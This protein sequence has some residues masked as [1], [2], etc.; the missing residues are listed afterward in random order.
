MIEYS[1]SFGHISPTIAGI[2]LTLLAA[3]PVV[4]ASRATWQVSQPGV[5]HFEKIPSP[6][7]QPAFKAFVPGYS[8]QARV[9]GFSFT[10]P[11]DAGRWS[12]VNGS[13]RAVPEGAMPTGAVTNYFLGQQRQ[14]WRTKVQSFEKIRYRS[15]WPGI[16]VVLYG[17]GSR[18]EYDFIVGPGAD[19]GQI[20]IRV[21]GVSRI[22]TDVDGSVIFQTDR[23]SFRQAPAILYQEI[24][25]KR[26]P[27]RGRYSLSPEGYVKLEVAD[28]DHRK[29]LIIDPVITLSVQ[30]GANGTESTAGIARD[31]L[32][33]LYLAGTTASSSLPAPTG[34]QTS[35]AG[36]SD[37]FVIKLDPQGNVLYSTY[38]GGSGDDHATGVA[39]DDQGNVYV[40][41]WTTSLNFPI[42]NALQPN[43]IG[44]R[45][46][47]LAKFSPDGQLLY[48]TYIGGSG[49]DEV[50]ALAVDSQ[51][52][53]F[54]AGVT[55]SKDFP[56]VGGIQGDLH[57]ATDGFVMKVNAGGDRIIFSTYL[58]GSDLDRCEAIAVDSIGRAYVA[59]STRS[60]DFPV[61]KPARPY[62][63]ETDAFIAR[64][65]SDGT[66]LEYA[67]FL[68]GSGNDEALGIAVDAANKAY[69]TGWTTSADFPV[70]SAFSA[71]LRGRQNAFVASLT[72]GGN[73]LTYSTYLGGTV[74][75]RG[76]AVR[77]NSDGEAFVTGWTRSPDFPTRSSVQSSLSGPQDA[78]FVRLSA[79]GA[80]IIDGSY[81]G[82][83]G[84]DDASAIL[85]DDEDRAYLAGDTVSR[86]AGR[87]D[88]PSS[89]RRQADNSGSG[90]FFAQ[91]DPCRYEFSWTTKSFDHLGGSD[92][93]L[94]T[95]NAP[96]CEWGV[97]EL[98]AWIS[99]QA[100]AAVGTG[101]LMLKVG[102][103]SGRSMRQGLIT[104]E[105]HKLTVS[106]NAL[107]TAGSLT[108]A[109]DYAAYATGQAVDFSGQFL[110]STGVA[111]ANATIGIQITQGSTNRSVS[112]AT[113]SAGN[114]TIVY[115]PPAGDVGVFQ[116]TASGTSN[117][118]TVTATTSF[119]IFG[120]PIQVP[121][122]S[123]PLGNTTWG[124]TGAVYVV[125]SGGVTVPQGATLT[126]QPGVIVKFQYEPGG[127]CY[128][129][130]YLDVKGSLVANGTAA[131]PIYFT[132][133]R[134]DAIGGDTNG[135]GNATSPA[136]GDWSGIRFDSG[137]TGSI[138]NAVIR[139]GGGSTYYGPN[140]A[141]LDIA[142][143]A[144][145]P[146]LGAGIQIT[147]SVTGLAISGSGTNVSLSGA[148]FARNTTGIALNTGS[149][150]ITGNT[151]TNNALGF[152]VAGATQG[153]ITNSTITTAAGGT[154]GQISAAYI[155]TLSGNTSSGAGLNIIKVQSG[156]H[157]TGLLTWG[158][159]IPYWVDQGGAH[160]D[161]G[162]TL[163]IQPGVIVKFRYAPGG[164]CYSS[165]YLEVQGTLAA[166]GTAA[167]PVYFTSDRDDTIGGDSNG[168]GGATTPAAGDWSGVRFDSG[169]TGSLSYAVIRYGGGSTYYGANYAALDIG[170]GSTQ[171]TLGAGIQFA[172]NLTGLAV[173]GSATN[174]AL[175]GATLIGNVTGILV[176][177][178]L[179]VIS[180]STLTANLT[181]ISLNGGTAT[182]SSN[183]ILANG[184]GVQVTGSGTN[185]LILSN[186][187]A[188]NSLAIHV[189]SNAAPLIHD[190]DIAGNTFGVQNDSSVIV[191]ATANFWGAS[192]GPS[193]A[194][195][196][197]GDK[198]STNVNFTPFLTVA[199]GATT[200]QFQI[201]LVTPSHGGNSGNA[202]LQVYGTG[203]QNGASLKIAGG[204]HPDLIG[205]NTQISDL[206]FVLTST[207]NL[208]GAAA[209]LRD[210]VV[211]NPSG[212]S[213]TLSGA[214]TVDQGGSPNIAVSLIGRNVMRAGQ[215]QPYFINV[216]NSGNVD[217]G[218]VRVWLVFPNYIQWQAPGQ[219]VASAGQQNGLTYVA[220]NVFAVPAGSN[221][222]IP[223][224]F[225][226]PDNP[227]YAH[228]NI[229][230]Q[231]WKEGQ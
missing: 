155:G 120:A 227:I 143:G 171:P 78:F 26:V 133:I 66:Q 146:T 49:Q 69:V 214:F 5:W 167:Q 21:E 154:A 112:G 185:P 149:A 173:S 153:S 124:Q 63:G 182:L 50:H 224:V 205:T 136:A 159:S 31:R 199:N 94:V 36:R 42:R 184:T 132:S 108:V 222:E 210:V 99:G 196:G 217:S 193:Q 98:P 85:I 127:C 38:L 53:A 126:I 103:N 30:I 178:G 157:V 52:N 67:T 23:G 141:A 208:T 180:G 3:Q 116:A 229:Q 104:I 125:P 33:N 10:G 107:Q 44:G 174:V 43:L 81:L 7:V 64:F 54:V 150:T 179:P 29:P 119:Q 9:G 172:N 114:Y 17:S 228:R 129:S 186:I 51:G 140:Y 201:L 25:G 48:S 46:G 191:D 122:G 230:V 100:T 27:V 123:L 166:N 82:G 197:S 204:G 226:A 170:T 83:S 89:G 221:T 95:P 97:T 57:G 15:V 102:P 135:D 183:S 134:D 1:R 110:D 164:C 131:Q 58:G 37:A 28:Y 73:D 101:A 147:D 88:F 138:S 14:N 231:V 137:A 218:S 169:A 151:F 220:F 177:S 16:D 20:G 189:L 105:G 128:T 203:F 142:S 18:F 213:T 206:G 86:V 6:S 194:G 13:R 115:Q 84:V 163:T 145:Q 176:N 70:V 8:F 223:V 12:W 55:A 207:L 109:T 121:S 168:D 225:M 198:V 152:Q 35:N 111:I 219:T 144:A 80:T 175:S 40:A 158:G 90:A 130:A 96:N 192:N 24:Q 76:L 4:A 161:S 41:G 2:C 19:P 162:G 22:H 65:K 212:A 190:N 72:E 61:L 87:N 74:E 79:T 59:G 156:T 211:T 165:A 45:E 34:T 92:Q 202:T 160:I 71:A 148:T 195:T 91:L 181:A 188:G 11:T 77:V 118:A 47:F 117:S 68:G 93:L 215:S 113:N 75:D 56:V 187:F 139:Y 60:P 32:G 39:L 106:Q 216:A 209:G 200:N 62:S